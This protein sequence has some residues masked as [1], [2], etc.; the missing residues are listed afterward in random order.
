METKANYVT[1][2]IIT[3]LLIAAA[4]GFVYWTA[5]PNQYADSAPLQILIPGSAAGL[6]RGSA[7]LFN[8][9]RVGQVERVFIDPNQPG[10]AIAEA[11]VDRLTP[12]TQST[13]ANI[14]IAGLSFAANI[15]LSGGNTAE[16]NL[17]AQA[18]EQGTIAQIRAN[19]SSVS[20]LTDTA[21]RLMTRADRMLTKLEDVIDEVG[22]PVANTARNAET[23]S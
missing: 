10:L 3:L 23:F 14:V 4:F 11:K 8:G 21:Q 22:G 5:R 2:G 7:V 19:P 9:V 12:L 16:P 15:D 18:A 6:D 17:L 1:V 13:T 20:N